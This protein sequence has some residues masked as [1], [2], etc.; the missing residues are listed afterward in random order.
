MIICFRIAAF[1]N[2]VAPNPVAAN[3]LIAIEI[4]QAILT[5]VIN[6]YDII[7]GDVDTL[8]AILDIITNIAELVPLTG[9]RNAQKIKE[10]VRVVKCAEFFCELSF[11]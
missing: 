9:V 5:I 8:D 3:V 7:N 10:R 2:K 4:A 6:C 11:I 1:V